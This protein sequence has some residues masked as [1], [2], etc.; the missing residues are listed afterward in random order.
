[1][2]LGDE[3]GHVWRYR[4]DIAAGIGVVGAFE[5][6]PDAPPV[7]AD[8]RGDER[9]E[10]GDDGV[11][12]PFQPLPGEPLARRPRRAFDGDGAHDSLL[13]GAYAPIWDGQLGLG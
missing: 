3:A 1:Q 6:A 4:G 11:Q 12:R 13:K 2:D 10:S 8:A 7:V 9:E 5:E